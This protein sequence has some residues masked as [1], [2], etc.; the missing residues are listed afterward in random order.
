[1]GLRFS[2]GDA[3]WSY[4]GFNHFRKRIVQSLGFDWDKLSGGYGYLT[5]DDSENERFIQTKDL[6]IPLIMHSDCDGYLTPGECRTVARRLRE[7]VSTWGNEDLF[8]QEQAIKLA[9]A[10]DECAEEGVPLEFT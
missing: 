2:R 9:D 5:P 7:I 6:I 1:M 3:G 8:D 4:R 10:M